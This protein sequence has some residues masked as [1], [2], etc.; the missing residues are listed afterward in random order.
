MAE[1]T[2][3]SEVLASIGTELLEA[4][5]NALQ[6]GKALMLFTECEIEL[7]VD[8]EKKGGGGFAIWVIK[9]E[10]GLTRT[11]HNTIHLKFVANPAEPMRAIQKHTG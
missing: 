5:K 3:L 7:A 9:L 6:R 1:Q 8:I 2:K 4:N 11:E 10:G